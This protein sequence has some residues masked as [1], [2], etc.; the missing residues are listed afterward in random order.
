[1]RLP[2]KHVVPRFLLRNP[3]V[4]V[5]RA[6]NRMLWLCTLKRAANNMRPCSRTLKRAANK[7]S[8]LRGLACSDTDRRV[9][10]RSRLSRRDS[11]LLTGC[12]S[13]RS[14]QASYIVQPRRGDTLLTG[15]FSFRS[16]QASHIAQPRRGDT[17]LTARF[18]VRKNSINQF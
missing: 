9:P 6:C 12:F 1:M 14:Q 8:P 7:V 10:C 11:T 4:G 15:C 5:W 2:Q 3:L 18:N 17:L 16:Q 13:F